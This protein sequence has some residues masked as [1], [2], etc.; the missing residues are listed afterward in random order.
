W[1]R[2]YQYLAGYQIA[3]WRFMNYGFSATETEPT[4][5]ELQ[6]A[7][8]PNRY[9]IQLYHRVASAAPLQGLDVLEVGCGRGGGASFVHR[10]HRPRSMTGVDFSQKAVRFCREHHRLAGLAFVPGDA[11]ALP[12]DDEAFDAVLN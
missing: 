5:L 8:E 11:E 6:P 4:P 2:W 7:D 10:Y 3:D 12:L 1:R 9:A